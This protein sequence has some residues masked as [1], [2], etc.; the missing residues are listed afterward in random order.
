MDGNSLAI[1]SLADGFSLIDNSKKQIFFFDDFLGKIALDKR[2]LA[3]KDADLLKFIQR[4]QKSRNARFILTT[5]AYIYEEGRRVSEN[6]GDKRLELAKYIL[7]VGV[8]TRQVKARILYNH[9]VVS[10][11]PSEYVGSLLESGALPDIVDHKNYNPR[12]IEWMTDKSRVNVGP[13][14]YPQEFV[15]AL[16]EPFDIWDRA[17][18][19]H[20]PRKAQRLFIT[21]FFCLPV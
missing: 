3:S 2:A 13:E 18:R 6:I 5:R 7:D 4:I 16:D 19:E 20:I 11:L 10:E 17:F 1:T 9:L 14:Q 8:Y 12:I 15:K 21:L